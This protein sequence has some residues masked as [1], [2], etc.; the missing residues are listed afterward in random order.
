MQIVFYV[1]SPDDCHIIKLQ[2]LYSREVGLSR[3]LKNLSHLVLLPF[4]E[5]VLQL[6]EILAYS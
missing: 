3:D 1:S 5:S 4:S 6:F 2:Y